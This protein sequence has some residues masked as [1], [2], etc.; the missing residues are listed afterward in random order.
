MWYKYTSVVFCDKIIFINEKKFNYKQYFHKLFTKHLPIQFL[1]CF[2]GAHRWY[3][4]VTSDYIDTYQYKSVKTD[5]AT[6]L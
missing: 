2:T 5:S 1:F 6:F 3:L 4:V